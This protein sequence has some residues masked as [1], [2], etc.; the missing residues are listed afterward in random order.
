[1]VVSERVSVEVS[2][3]CKQHR[4]RPCSP[5]DLNF[6]VPI[7][8][9]WRREAG[10][11]A[12]PSVCVALYESSRSLDRPSRLCATLFEWCQ[13]LDRSPWVSDRPVV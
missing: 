4:G 9:V 11:T 13:S 6:R 5:D 12:F 7:P 3:V 1:M 8:S 10:L 2:G